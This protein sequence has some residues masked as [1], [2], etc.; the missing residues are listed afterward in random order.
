[1]NDFFST[2]NRIFYRLSQLADLIFLSVLWII[3]CMSVILVIPSTTALY[4]TTYKVV[5]REYGMLW[6]EFWNSLTGSCKQGILLSILFL[7]GMLLVRF[8]FSFSALPGLAEGIRFAYYWISWL[9]AVMITLVSVYICPLLS[10]FHI[11]LGKLLGSAFLLSLRHLG[12]TLLCGAIVLAA[13]AGVYFVYILLLLFPA[14]ACFAISFPMEKVLVQYMGE[15]SK[16]PSDP[17][18]WYWED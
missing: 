12:T 4:H 8:L 13:M 7:L 9:T 3:C 11:P 5:R 10:R 1:M 14:L 16:D 15:P 17:H 18:S 2:D 6:K